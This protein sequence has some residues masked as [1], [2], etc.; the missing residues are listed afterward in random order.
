MSQI[1]EMPDWPP[2]G[3]AF[4]YPEG[5]F[6][7]GSTGQRFVV[8]NGQWVRVRKPSAVPEQREIGG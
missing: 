2:K 7:D 1:D 6:R 4:N 8:K 5:T 3:S